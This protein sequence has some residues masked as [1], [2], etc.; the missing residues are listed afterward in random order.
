MNGL[1]AMA[2]P[3]LRSKIRAVR[4]GHACLT[5]GREDPKMRSAQLG[6]WQRGLVELAPIYEYHAEYARRSVEHAARHGLMAFRLSTD[7]F[8]LLDC[9]PGLRRLVPSLARL[10]GAIADHGIHVS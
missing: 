1:R 7:I 4:L 8:P 6:R 5:R 10:R 2:M 3:P 9:D